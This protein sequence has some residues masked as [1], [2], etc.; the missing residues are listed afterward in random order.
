MIA[1]PTLR[2]RVVAAAIAMRG[3]ETH[4]DLA[5]RINL[6]DAYRLTEHASEALARTIERATASVEENMDLIRFPEDGIWI[7]CSDAPRRRDVEA[8]PGAAHPLNVGIF[9]CPDP[10]DLDR[11]VMLTAWDFPDGTVHHSYAAA[12][13]S[14]TDISERAFLARTRYG[15]GQVESIARMINL[16][17][18]YH[19]PGFKEEV[20]FTTEMNAS[21]FG[22]RVTEKALDD[23]RR[24]V[25]LEVPFALAALLLITATEGDIRWDETS[26]IRDVGLHAFKQDWVD[27]L[28]LGRFK[29]K[30]FRRW[31]DPRHPS[32]RYLAA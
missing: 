21:E 12:A 1:H 26:K 30:G 16:A 32:L 2:D 8:L 11:I 23:A 19:P 3:V 24:D 13:F 17:M 5:R 22:F 10:T 15:K 18:V 28:G 31:G 9:V 6:A 14:L 7:E 27:Q 25:V 29:K 4:L 20:T